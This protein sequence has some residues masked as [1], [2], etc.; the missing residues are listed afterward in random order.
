MLFL[1]GVFAYLWNA[2]VSRGSRPAK[3]GAATKSLTG[4]A[5]LTKNKGIFLLLWYNE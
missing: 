5:R 1:Q 2:S 3:G 4:Y